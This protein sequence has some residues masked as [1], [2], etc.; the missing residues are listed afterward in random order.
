MELRELQYF[1]QVVKDK[2]FTKAAENLYISQPAISK[3]IRKLE[4]ELNA[5]LFDMQPDGAY[6]T[7]C[8][9]VLYEKATR[10]LKEIDTIPDAI[11]AVKAAASGTLTFGTSP[12]LNELFCGEIVLQ[13]H[14]MYPNI[15]I[16]VIEQGALAIHKMLK[17]REIDINICNIDDTSGDVERRP[18][19]KDDMV[20]CMI[21]GNPLA[22]KETVT[23]HDLR[24]ESFNL[25]SPTTYFYKLIIEGCR[26]SGYIPKVNFSSSNITSLIKMTVSGTGIFIM[27]KMYAEYIAY[28]GLV[29]VPLADSLKWNIA[30]EWM[31]TAYLS[32]AATLF[33]EH[34]QNYFLNKLKKD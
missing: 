15:E 22:R 30:L 17:N 8:G 6:L 24:E 4:K 18:L 34:A 27:P 25:Y 10:I 28:P 14:Q 29:M 12:M 7:D 19:F 26:Q 16:R 20:V 23:F 13:F 1:I 3:S 21:D 32:H 5:K 11:K 33:I 31:K 9:K 2:R